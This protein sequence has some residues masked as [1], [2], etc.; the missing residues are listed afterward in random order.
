MTDTKLTKEEQ[1]RYLKAFKEG[2]LEKNIRL[3]GVDYDLAEFRGRKKV[4][5]LQQSAN[6]YDNNG[7][8]YFVKPPKF[9]E[10]YVIN[11][12]YDADSYTAHQIKSAKAFVIWRMKNPQ[13][14]FRSLP[15]S[16]DLK[17]TSDGTVVI[18]CQELKL[19]D[20]Q[21][22]YKRIIRTQMKSLWNLEMTNT[23]AIEGIMLFEYL[24]PF[25]EKKM[26]EI[27]KVA[28]QM[29]K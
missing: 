5:V 3:D 24:L 16:Y 22:K 9:V 23:R 2:K 14:A 17:L 11:T 25:I 19:S 29:K 20:W 7:Y 15:Q 4:L 1:A 26:V 10:K 21:K 13:Y 6:K 12:E 28:K 8:L 18:G 27:Q